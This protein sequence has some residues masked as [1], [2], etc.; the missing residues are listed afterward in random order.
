MNLTIWITADVGDDQ[1]ALN[2]ILSKIRSFL[3]QPQK[4]INNAPAFLVTGMSTEVGFNK[5]SRFKME[6]KVHQDFVSNLPK[7]ARQTR[8]T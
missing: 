1:E 5:P 7:K 8:Q 6:Y 3:E 2:D 4:E